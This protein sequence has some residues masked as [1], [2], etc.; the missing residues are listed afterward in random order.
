MAI[1]RWEPVSEMISP[2][3]AINSLLAESFVRPGGSPAPDGAATLRLVVAET[4]GEFLIK[5]SLPGIPSRPTPSPPRRSVR[6]RKAGRPG[7]PERR[8]ASEWSISAGAISRRGDKASEVQE[9]TCVMS[10]DQIAGDWKQ[11]AGKNGTATPRTSRWKKNNDP[12]HS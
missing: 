4:E 11:F 1:Q 7:A 3:D 9:R 2:R 12:Q 8:T 10:W 5:A 6:P